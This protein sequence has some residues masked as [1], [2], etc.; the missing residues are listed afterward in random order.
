MNKTSSNTQGTEKQ[1]CPVQPKVK[2]QDPWAHQAKIS[3]IKYVI[4]I[5]SVK[6][7]LFPK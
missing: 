1:Q 2:A 3:G 7:K 5:A 6:D 4:A